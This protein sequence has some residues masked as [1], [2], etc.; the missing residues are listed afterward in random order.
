MLNIL[1]KSYWVSLATSFWSAL[2]TRKFWSEFVLMTIGMVFG[3]AAV[4]YFLLPSNLIAGTISGF[5]IVLNYF[6]G[7]TPDTFSYWMLGT[8]AILLIMAFVLVGEEFGAKTVYTGMILGPMCQML[9]HIYPYTNFTHQ[10]VEM[11]DVLAQLQ[12]GAQVLDVNGNP[13]LLSRSG[14]VLM[15]VRDS[16]MSAGVGLGDL[17]FDVLGF[18]LL[19]SICQA[20]EFRIGAST[21]GL[22]IVAK[23]L[24]KLFHWDIGMCVTVSGAVVC[25]SGFFIHDFR[26]VMIGL[27]TTWFNGVVVDYF[28]ASL[29]RRKRVCVITNEWDR[30]R[31][32]IIDD[33]VRGCSLYKV[34]GGYSDQE[35]IEIQA[36]LTQDE[37]GRLMTFMEENNIHAF[38]TAGNC[39]EV[40]G[41]WLK[42]RKRHGHIEISQ[43]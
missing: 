11:P 32:F 7:G 37:F 19:L 18:V 40:Y 9:D 29:N 42:H 38:T 39:S 2:F 14:E 35:T 34:T 33:L 10:V 26:M 6:F 17:W 5:C 12:A 13:Y 20:F 21:G 24:S 31:R 27:I 22:D 23:I 28:T 43:D 25:L 8:N 15:Q 16:V 41:L 3:A 36:L 1:S 30:V 4:E